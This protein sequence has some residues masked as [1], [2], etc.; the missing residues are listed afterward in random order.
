MGREG[1]EDAVIARAVSIQVTF[2]G[3]S[4]EG[5][6]SSL[7]LP[8]AAQKGPLDRVA[9]LAFGAPAIAALLGCGQLYQGCVF[10]VAWSLEQRSME[11]LAGAACR[12]SFHWEAIG[13]RASCLAIKQSGTDAKGEERECGRGVASCRSELS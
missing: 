4:E 3:A 10:G 11:G 8:T 5:E 13:G 7:E 1:C 12:R 6:S 2:G 9:G